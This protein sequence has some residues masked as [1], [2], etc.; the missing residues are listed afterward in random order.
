[1]QSLSYKL[2]EQNNIINSNKQEPC[3]LNC[4]YLHLKSCIS[5][6]EV[7][8]LSTNTS[9]ANCSLGLY[10]EMVKENSL[11]TVN[12]DVSITSSGYSRETN[13]IQR[14]VNQQTVNSELDPPVS[15][16]N[17]HSNE[18]IEGVQLSISITKER[19]ATQTTHATNEN[20]NTK[21]NAGKSCVSAAPEQNNIEWLIRLPLIETPNQA[22][23]TSFCN[24][25]RKQTTNPDHKFSQ[26]LQK[27]SPLDRSVMSITPIQSTNAKSTN[28]I[29]T[30]NQ[31][32]C[33]G[34]KNV[35][36]FCASHR[37]SAKSVECTRQYTCPP[38]LNQNPFRVCRSRKPHS[39]RTAH[40]HY[41]LEWLI[42]LDTVFGMT[43]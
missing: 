33:E 42:H 27:I 38:L 19:A 22:N 28:Q 11:P 29:N 23:Q 24:T 34:S 12:A 1:M 36:K 8:L 7:K 13:K 25:N 17:N 15:E 4:E 21:P 20:N 39:Y 37:A 6:L 26:S 2:P 30:Y 40:R 3:K 18:S 10:G 31:W 5:E 9:N 35:V 41:S 32:H 14:N 16:M 43:R